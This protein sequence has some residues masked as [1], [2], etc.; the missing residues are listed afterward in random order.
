MGS[1]V[2]SSGWDL[3]VSLPLGLAW[4]EMYVSNPDTW[5]LGKSMSERRYICYHRVTGMCVLALWEL[6]SIVRECL[7]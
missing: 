2:G 3:H 5:P 1:F 6:D 4:G 7:F